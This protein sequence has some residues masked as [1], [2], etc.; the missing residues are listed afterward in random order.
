MLKIS[1]QTVSIFLILS[2]YFLSSCQKNNT[3]GPQ[4]MKV[5]EGTWYG[6]FAGEKIVFTIIEGE[7]EQSVT[8]TGTAYL[9]SDTSSAA[10]QIMNGGRNDTSLLFSLY[11]IPLVGKEDYHVRGE[12][13]NQFFSGN[14]D[15]LNSGGKIVQSG[16]FQVKRIP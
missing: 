2:F 16:T 14:F 7:F 3:V 10:Y 11:K 13:K 12:I 5:A 8:I 9:Q 15:R 6:D 4:L 1:R